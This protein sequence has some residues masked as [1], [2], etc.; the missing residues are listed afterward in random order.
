MRKWRCRS[1]RRLHFRD[2]MVCSSC[3]APRDENQE[4]TDK[5]KS[6]RKTKD[7]KEEALLQKEKGKV[8]S[9]K[10]QEQY[11]KKIEMNDSDSTDS[12]DRYYLPPDCDDKIDDKDLGGIFDGRDDNDMTNSKT[13]IDNLDLVQDDNILYYECNSDYESVEN[14]IKRQ[15]RKDTEA[16]SLALKQ[17]SRSIK[18]AEAYAGCQCGGLVRVDSMSSLPPE[19]TNR[20]RDFKYA[21]EKRQLVYGDHA[22]WGILGMFEFLAGIRTDIEWAD[23]ICR[24]RIASEP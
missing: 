2:G 19:Y 8:A 1:C 15:N 10:P 16:E 4:V 12:T 5:R 7:K 21:R 20:L 3:G 23:E 24:R 14:A 17:I 22:P 9:I 11:N 13:I 18:S 6:R